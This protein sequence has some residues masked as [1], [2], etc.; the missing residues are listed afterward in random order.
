M[1]LDHFAVA[2]ATLDEA[3]AVVEEAL[4]VKMQPGGQHQMFG[5]HNRLLALDGGLYLEAIA[6]DPAAPDPGRA[7]WFDLDQFSGPARLTNWI[8]RTD[9]LQASIDALPDGVGSPVALSRGDLLWS[10]AVPTNGQLPYDNLFPALIQ[11]HGDLHPG[12]ML[13]P[14]G[15]ALRRLVVRHPKA[16]ELREKVQLNDSRVVF[17]AGPIGLLAEIDTPNGLRVLW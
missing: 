3:S 15:C 4:G 11:W 10:M 9:D 2:A 6:V 16:E 12:A 17:E 13:T 8:C 14:A 7:R 5:T 1:E